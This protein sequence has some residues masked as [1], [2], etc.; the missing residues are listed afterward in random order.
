M[1]EENQDSQDAPKSEANDTSMKITKG[2]AVRGE[3]PL[4]ISPSSLPVP[5]AEPKTFYWCGVTEDCPRQVIHAGGFDFPAYTQKQVPIGDSTTET[6]LSD[7]RFAGRI[8]AMTQRAVRKCLDGIATRIVRPSVP[9]PEI[10]SIEGSKVRKH[11]PEVG[12]VPLAKFVYM[13]EVED[14][15]I[16]RTYPQKNVMTLLGA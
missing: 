3:R 12:D 1:A 13:V 6:K 15:D 16:L 7:D 8:H 9:N 10:R 14:P 11:V 5:E 2:R 4:F